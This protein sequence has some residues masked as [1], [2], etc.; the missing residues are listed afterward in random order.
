MGSHLLPFFAARHSPPSQPALGTCP[1]SQNAPPSQPV[2]RRSSSC[3]GSCGSLISDPSRALTAAQQ[4]HVI[5]RAH[6][7]PA[8]PNLWANSPRPMSTAAY[9]RLTSTRGLR[10]PKKPR[11]ASAGSS[12]GQ[13]RTQPGG[14]LRRREARCYGTWRFRETPLR[15]D[16]SRCCPISVALTLSGL[17][18]LGCCDFMPVR[19]CVRL[20]CCLKAPPG[21]R[22]STRG[23][24]PDKAN[25]WGLFSDPRTVSSTV[26]TVSSFLVTFVSLPP[27]WDLLQPCSIRC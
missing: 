27:A 21:A 24:N 2:L 3:G 17:S 11:F 12:S 7:L 9:L 10:K 19:V 15:L 18:R 16:S 14:G 4:M 20:A 22:K 26:S 8:M 6:V 5:E 13:S 23:G 1:F 25:P